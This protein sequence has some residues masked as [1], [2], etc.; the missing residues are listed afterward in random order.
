MKYTFMRHSDRILRI[1]VL[2]AASA[3]ATFWRETDYYYWDIQWDSTCMTKE[4]RLKTVKH[5]R[6]SI[7][8]SSGK[9]FIDEWSTPVCCCYLLVKCAQPYGIQAVIQQTKHFSYHH[10]SQS[11]LSSNYIID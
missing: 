4:K 5:H 1:L 8:R 9:H 10:Q 3:A 11:F 7:S 6:D 2:T